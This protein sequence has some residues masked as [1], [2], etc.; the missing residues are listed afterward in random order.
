[1]ASLD[2]QSPFALEKIFNQDYQVPESFLYP[3]TSASYTKT[4]SFLIQKV[5]D[6]GGW[7]NI[8]KGGWYYSVPYGGDWIVLW[9]PNLCKRIGS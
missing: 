9:Q 4:N 5:T 3:G 7:G 8:G 2:S 6:T 1:M